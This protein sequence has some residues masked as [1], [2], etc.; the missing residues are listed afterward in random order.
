MDKTYRQEMSESERLKTASVNGNLQNHYN[1][2]IMSAMSSQITSLTIVY[3]SAY[4][5]ADLRKHQSSVSLTFVGGEFTG[6]RWI[7]RINGQ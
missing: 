4:S 2:V 7:P 6:D 5:G 1:D 3:S